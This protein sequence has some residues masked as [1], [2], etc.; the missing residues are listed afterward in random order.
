MPSSGTFRLTL[1]KRETEVL[2]LVAD[3]LANNQIAQLLLV[4]PETVKSCVE[5]IRSKLAA[6]NRAHAVSVALRHGLID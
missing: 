6:S 5:V 1:T 3:G 4:S 2:Q